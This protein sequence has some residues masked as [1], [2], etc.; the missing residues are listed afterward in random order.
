[1][2]TMKLNVALDA[3]CLYCSDEHAGFV[4]ASG[5]SKQGNR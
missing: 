3:A 1:M 4:L 2:V 5:A